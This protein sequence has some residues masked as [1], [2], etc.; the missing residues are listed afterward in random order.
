MTDIDAFHDVTPM[1]P[2]YHQLEPHLVW[3]MV[4]A[5]LPRHSASVLLWLNRGY[6]PR[7][8]WTF[9]L[10]RLSSSCGDRSDVSR[11]L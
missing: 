9:L 5:T 6:V 2:G 4:S 11:M 8:T 1:N 10:V 7:T 3:P